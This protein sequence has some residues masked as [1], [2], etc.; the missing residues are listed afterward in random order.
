[1][2]GLVAEKVIGLP[3]LV[4][5]CAYNPAHRFGLGRSKG[6]IA[7]GRDADMPIVDMLS[8]PMPNRLPTLLTHHFMA[9]VRPVG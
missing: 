2:L 3:D 8:S 7:V 1:M 6:S 4:R 5:I 9:R